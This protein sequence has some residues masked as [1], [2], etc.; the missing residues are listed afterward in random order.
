M[1]ENQDRE[2]RIVE[3]SVGSISTG[4]ILAV[5]D[6][7]ERFAP[8]FV[9]CGHDRNSPVRRSTSK[10]WPQALHLRVFFIRPVPEPTPVVDLKLVLRNEPI[11][12]G[13]GKSHIGEC[14]CYV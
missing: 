4:L 8:R 11:R 14:P 3:K 12:R 6:L 7:L 5:C 13:G 1:R 2:D 10:T 9:V